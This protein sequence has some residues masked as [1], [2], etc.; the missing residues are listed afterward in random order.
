MQLYIWTGA[1]KPASPTAPL[2]PC[3][4]RTPDGPH[5]GPPFPQRRPAAAIVPHSCPRPRSSPPPH[6]MPQHMRASSRKAA[7][8]RAALHP[9]RGGRG[10]VSV[11]AVGEPQCTGAQAGRNGMGSRRPSERPMR[12]TRRAGFRAGFKE[13]GVRGGARAVLQARR[14]QPRAQG[15]DKTGRRRG[16]GPGAGRPPGKIGAPPR[17]GGRRARGQ[18]SRS[19][20]TS[21]A[22]ARGM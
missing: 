2:A 22:D 17:A 9:H 3:K 4:Q 18:N 15:L 12:R 8:T 10:A 5:R 20:V 14:G 11:S 6:A 7:V 16:G 1:L 19:I 21:A 13:S